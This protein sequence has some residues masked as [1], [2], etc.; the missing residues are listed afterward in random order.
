MVFTINSENTTFNKK[1]GKT[2][3]CVSDNT[4]VKRPPAE[5]LP[6]QKN[7]INLPSE[8]I[9]KTSSGMSYDLKSLMYERIDAIFPESIRKFE[10]SN[11]LTD[12]CKKYLVHQ[13]TAKDFLDR[14]FRMME[15]IEKSDNIKDLFEYMT[16]KK[17]SQENLDKLVKGEI[18]LK[19]EREY[20]L[21]SGKNPSKTPSHPYL[22][23]DYQ[24][25]TDKKNNDGKVYKLSP[26]Q[27][28]KYNV[29]YNGL[30]KDYQKK[31]AELLSLG[32]L[33]A[34]KSNNQC[35]LESLYKILTTQRIKGLD[36]VKLV[37][38]SIDILENPNII[39]QLAEKFPEKQLNEAAKRY[40]RGIDK[41]ELTLQTQMY[42]IQNAAQTG[43]PLKKYLKTDGTVKQPTEQEKYKY[44]E[45]ELRNRNAVG[46]CAAASIEYDMS[47]KYPAEFFSLV[48]QLTSPTGK[49]LKTYLEQK[50]PT[51]I[52]MGTFGFGTVLEHDENPEIE[53]KKVY[54]KADDEAYYLAKIQNNNKSKNERSMIDILTQSLIMNLAS[55][56]EYNSLTDRRK[57]G[58][59]FVMENGGL[60]SHEV[61]FAKSILT[62]K[63]NV[64]VQYSVG[65]SKNKAIRLKP[66]SIIKEEIME[67]LS[68]GEN[69]VIGYNQSGSFGHEITI[70]GHIINDNG[71]EF[72][73]CQD[74]CQENA[75]P[76]TLS[77]EFILSNINSASYTAED[78]SNTPEL[79]KKPKK[80]YPTCLEPVF[81]PI[82][83]KIAV[84]PPIIVV[85]SGQ[86]LT[87]WNQHCMPVNIQP[88]N[89]L[90]PVEK[91]KH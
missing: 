88:Q 75:H 66:K 59:E 31:F 85:D 37:Q 25:I 81:N 82:Q 16:G 76:K 50:M 86:I 17:Y 8:L 84:Q 77:E 79:L 74:S 55:D 2:L 51:V 47:T 5:L 54:L 89:I 57:C 22:S 7:I 70:T 87:P 52:P 56:N 3:N 12:W 91:K 39:T 18:E 60:Y 28:V 20:K 35:V 1:C 65:L 4:I 13:T 62:G 45:T 48:E 41:R 73:V 44:I 19:I 9:F 21:F 14:L 11:N 72:F 71:E 78:D 40:Y 43:Q 38:E 34:D 49:I 32:K 36:A 46:T 61:N 33:T 83:P 10:E 67:A 24:K 29:I 64:S 42:N 53:E 68:R 26:Q 63:E 69:V 90:N 15:Y 6:L 80:T 58:D 23:S 27:Q 30:N